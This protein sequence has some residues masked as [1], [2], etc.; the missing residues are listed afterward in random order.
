M[1]KIAVI[2]DNPDNRMLVR[3]LLEDSYELMEY[4]NGNDALEAMRLT[5]PDLILLDI[6]LPG[7]DGVEVLRLIREDPLLAPL[8]V[9]ALTAHAMGTARE[10]FLQ[11]GFD[12][13]VSKPITDED[14]LLDSIR[15][16]LR[17]SASD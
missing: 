5:P 3:A 14:V 13:Y 10:R 12:Q 15:D 9:I 16:L 17:K 6:S 4:D 1:T 2:E 8:P 7:I 11:A